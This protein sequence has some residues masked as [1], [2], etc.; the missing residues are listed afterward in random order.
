M[1]FNKIIFHLSLSEKEGFMDWVEK[2]DY[3]LFDFDG[4]LV[5]TE[6]L[7][8]QAYVNMLK[9]RG[10]DLDWSFLEFCQKAHIESTGLKEAIYAK[11]PRLEEEEPSWRVL[12]EEKKKAYL[13]LLI[14]G[15]VHLMQ[16]VEKLL[17]NLKEKGKRSCVVTNSLKE[18]TEI[19]QARLPILQTI[20]HWITRE[21]YSLPK[22]DPE[23][24]KRA[25][26]LYSQIGDRI[27]GFEDTLKGLKAL[28]H[29]PVK[30]VLISSIDYPELTATIDPN[31]SHFSSFSEIKESLV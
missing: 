31:V 25:I 11:F 27:I 7:H 13:S 15:K 4:L 17:I 23:C 26:E 20:D 22:P 18:H 29:T 14:S 9:R 5:N 16:G 24:Y 28:L 1:S 19:A 8:H 30:P 10:Y 12:Y 6:H 21:D 2:F 3:F